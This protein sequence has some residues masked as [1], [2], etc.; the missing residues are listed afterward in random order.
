[1][2]FQFS[3]LTC[4]FTSLNGISRLTWPVLRLRGRTSKLMIHPLTI[5]LMKKSEHRKRTGQSPFNFLQ[6]EPFQE[7]TWIFQLCQIDSFFSSINPAKFG[8]SRR[9]TVG[10]S[11]PPLHWF[12]GTK[13]SAPSSTLTFHPSFVARAGT[14]ANSTMFM[15]IWPFVYSYNA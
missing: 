11:K 7:W 15:H 10:G 12:R 5:R 2:I 13:F 9:C 3:P 8:R 1:M 14:Q 4:V 6:N